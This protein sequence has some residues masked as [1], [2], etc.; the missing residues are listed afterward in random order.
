MYLA[1]T[2]LS[3]VH[4]HV[5]SNRVCTKN[6]STLGWRKPEPIT[7]TNSTA[8]LARTV[9]LDVRRD[10]NGT[11]VNPEPKIDVLKV[12]LGFRRREDHN[13]S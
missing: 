9:R 2:L 7:D 1:V 12:S 11:H 8:K 13:L 3:Q 10:S 4:N 6:G 5:D